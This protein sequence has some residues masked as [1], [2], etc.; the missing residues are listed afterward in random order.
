MMKQGITNMCS[1][2]TSSKCTKVRP[3]LLFINQ[4]I[5]QL[6]G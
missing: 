2:E 1:A 5:I 3:S 4:D 6:L